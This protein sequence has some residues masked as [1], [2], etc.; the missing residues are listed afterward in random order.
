MERFP[1]SRSASS[2]TRIYV[3]QNWLSHISR[4]RVYR[5]VGEA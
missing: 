4:G 5:R 3:E 1:K 2:V